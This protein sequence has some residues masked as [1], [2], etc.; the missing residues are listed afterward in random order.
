MLEPKGVRAALWELFLWIAWGMW[1]GGLSFYA[2]VV[3][4]IGTEQIG[5]VGQGFITQ[6]VTQWHN[7]FSMLF[8]LCLAIE[9]FNR[10]TRSVWIVVALLATITIALL[11]A[12]SMLSQQMD[13]QKKTVPTNFYS[14]HAIYLWIT[15][16]EWFVG[17]SVP[18]FLRTKTLAISQTS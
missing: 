6:E 5:S 8:V 1:W 14:Q 13:F 7:V 4:P 3:V 11:I 17:M 2:I 15:A 18:L 10:K 12:H 16:A 9:A